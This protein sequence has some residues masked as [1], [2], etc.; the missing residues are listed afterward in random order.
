MIT[1]KKK[2]YEEG[3]SE[4]RLGWASWDN[5]SLTKKS[6]KYSYKDK[7]GRIS[8]G[9]P[10]LP[11]RVVIDLLIFAAENGELFNE[12]NNDTQKKEEKPIATLSREELD[13]ERKDLASAVVIMSDLQNRF[14][15]ADF[16]LAMEQL[17][18]R[19]NQVKQAID[20]MTL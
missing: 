14:P 13:K 3:F 9:S 15:S 19:K 7:N 8:R 1:T 2:V 20:L 18:A 5:G 10:E 4:L 6:L 16:K 12:L 17:E 11:I